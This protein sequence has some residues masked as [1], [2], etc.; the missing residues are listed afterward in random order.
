MA[1]MAVTNHYSL[2]NVRPAILGRKATF[3]SSSIAGDY[4][5]L[6]CKCPESCVRT[7]TG[8]CGGVGT[9]RRGELATVCGKLATVCGEDARVLG[10]G[11]CSEATRRATCSRLC[12]SCSAM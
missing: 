12:L 4:C 2:A 6:G 3:C 10:C 5:C 1:R 11:F 8:G 7:L 9:C